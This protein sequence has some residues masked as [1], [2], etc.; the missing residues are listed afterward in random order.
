MI[1]WFK[2]LT[3]AAKGLIVAGFVAVLLLVA[4]TQLGKV[5]GDTPEPERTVPAG[6]PNEPGQGGSTEEPTESPTTEPTAVPT[7]EL[8]QE[9]QLPVE[10]QQ[11]AMAVAT[12][13]FLEF[14]NVSADEAPEA[15]QARMAP[16][17]TAD[18]P[19]LSESPLGD[20][21]TTEDEL[22]IYSEAS[23]NFS[24]PIGGT[25]DEF[26]VLIGATVRGQITPPA[27][28]GELPYIQKSTMVIFEVA[29][30]KQGDGWKITNIV[31]K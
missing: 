13:G 29:L 11:A 17:F 28:S 3:P 8:P 5:S 6:S 2:Q 21:V 18:S 15:R 30:T 1:D 25:T 4:I 16:Y 7:P 26:F 12:P 22:K 14:Y 20:M 9:T 19:I 27:D 24:E 31:E 23:L 10:E